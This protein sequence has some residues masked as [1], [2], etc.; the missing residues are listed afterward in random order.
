MVR[1]LNNKREVVELTG[2]VSISIDQL[3][4]WAETLTGYMVGSWE[5]GEVQCPV[6][7]VRSRIVP[8]DDPPHAPDCII[9]IYV[10]ELERLF[11]EIVKTDGKV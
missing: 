9:S 11:N 7:F 8:F 6:C 2:N 3:Q 5:D 1:V 4:T 10:R